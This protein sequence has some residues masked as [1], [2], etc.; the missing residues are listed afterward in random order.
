MI[1]HI[2]DLAE[3]YAVGTLDEPQAARVERHAAEC[4][5]C[6]ARLHEAESAAAAIAELQARPLHQPSPALGARLHR[7]LD[8]RSRRGA[9]TWHPFAAGIAAAIVLALVPT[10]VAVDR[11]TALQAMRQDERALARLASA[12]TQIDHAQFMSGAAPM[13]A[14]VL[15][16]P[17][18]DWY[19]VVV[20]HPRPG[21]QVA[22]VH[23]GR[24]EKLGTVEIHGESGT[25]YL[26]VNHKM[27]EL[28]L[29][30]DGNV[31]ADAHLAY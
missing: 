22:Y 18:G 15:Y 31:L 7:S 19:Y 25:L 12:G 30:Q 24:M 26:P 29:V 16:G 11:N 2:D 3:L 21:M 9:L 6:A 14:K 13:N 8:R 23:G 27:D 1:E 20:M 28:A 10:F 17:K 5:A 4:S